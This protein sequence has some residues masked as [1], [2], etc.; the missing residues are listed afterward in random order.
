MGA[1]AVDRSQHPGDA[2]CS[3]APQ[4]SR[5]KRST[6]TRRAGGSGQCRRWPTIVHYATAAHG[7]QKV[8]ACT[9][10]MGGRTD[11]SMEAPD[12]PDPPVWAS[13]SKED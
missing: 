9:D 5:G 13:A 7:L 2:G 11:P 12:P 8:F 1:A 3:V 4:Q 10:P 6:G